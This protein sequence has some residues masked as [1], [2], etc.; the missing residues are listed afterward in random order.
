VPA[1]FGGRHYATVLH[2]IKKVEAMRCTDK[3]LNLTIMRLM[4]ACVRPGA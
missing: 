3:A 2:S 1:E 4:D